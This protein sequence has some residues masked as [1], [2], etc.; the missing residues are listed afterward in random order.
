[1]K[2]PWLWLLATF[3]AWAS[4]ILALSYGQEV[5]DSPSYHILIYTRTP[6]PTKV[7]TPV[8][9][10]TPAPT[11]TPVACLKIMNPASG[12]SVTGTINVTTDDTCPHVWF[13]T[14][15]VD[16]LT[17]GSFPPGLASFNSTTYANGQHT[18]MVTAQSQNPGS[19]ML[20][21]ATIPISVSNAH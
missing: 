1:M 4:I 14:L 13:E 9:T 11:A 3:V 16:G 8:P 21:C 15:Y 7:V 12:A 2:Y 17:V 6:T 5:A 20:G 10:F 19:V 18:L